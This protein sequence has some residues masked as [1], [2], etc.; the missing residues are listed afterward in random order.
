MEL[1]SYGDGVTR[2]RFPMTVEKCHSE[3]GL[4]ALQK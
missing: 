3:F 2:A 4:K 1:M